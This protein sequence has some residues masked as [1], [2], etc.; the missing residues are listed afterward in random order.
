MRLMWALSV[1]AL[2]SV[3]LALWSVIYLVVNWTLRFFQ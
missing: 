2:F 3:A 1:L